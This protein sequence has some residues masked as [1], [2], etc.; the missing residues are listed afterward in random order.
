MYE[1][2]EFHFEVSKRDSEWSFYAK[3]VVVIISF[4]PRISHRTTQ[5]RFQIRNHDGTVVRD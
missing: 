2:R 3:E 4:M 1:G 5:R